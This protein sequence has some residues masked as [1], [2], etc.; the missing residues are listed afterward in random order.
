M[1]AVSVD[2]K[3]VGLQG[4]TAILDTGTTLIIAPPADAVA[5]H[6]QIQGAQSD[7]QGGFIIPCTLNT[8]IALTFDGTSFAIDPRDLAIQPIDPNNPAGDCVSG[9]ASGNIGG[10]QEWLVCIHIAVFKYG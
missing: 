9:I 2:G 1:A 10:A 5:V 6:Q 4:R 3:D 8:T 7:G